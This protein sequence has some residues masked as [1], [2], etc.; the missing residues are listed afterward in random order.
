MS[1]EKVHEKDGLFSETISAELL[2]IQYHSI[3]ILKD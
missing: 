3:S 2:F 1:T